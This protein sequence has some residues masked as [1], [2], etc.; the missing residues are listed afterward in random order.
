MEGIVDTYVILVIM[1][2]L[3]LNFKIFILCCYVQTLLEELSFCGQLGVLSA[4]G[5]WLFHKV[6]YNNHVIYNIVVNDLKVVDY[7]L[8]VFGV[9]FSYPE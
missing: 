8:H 4:T 9:S 2:S 7:S 6:V 3:F 5:K 1:M